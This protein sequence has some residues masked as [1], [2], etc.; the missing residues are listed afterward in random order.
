VVDGF[1]MFE[2]DYG[3]RAI[4]SS[5]NG[6]AG[7]GESHGM[8]ALKGLENFLESLSSRLKAFNV[9]A[10]VIDTISNELL[11]SHQAGLPLD[12]MQMRSRLAELGVDV[13]SILPQAGRPELT[14]P[15]APP[16]LPGRPE[17][18]EVPI[19]PTIVVTEPI[20]DSILARLKNAGISLEVIE[21]IRRE[22]W[23]GI[24]LGLPLDLRQVRARLGELGVDWE[25][26]QPE[27]PELPPSGVPTLPG[28]PEAPEIPIMPTIVVTEPIA[29][30]ILARL[31]NAGISLEVI[32]TIR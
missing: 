11:A 23:D 26:L 16:T 17:V 2:Q 12:L 21:T 32:E 9:S 20:A 29:E 19:M 22:I 28:R 30:S 31:K 14:P 1:L 8:L 15:S 10:D 27:Y 13:E 18:P 3:G 6:P 24:T 4:D 5:G 7:S 25:K